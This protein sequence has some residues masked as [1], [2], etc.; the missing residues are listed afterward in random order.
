LSKLAWNSGSS[1]CSLSAEIIGMIRPLRQDAF[2]EHLLF[3]G[4]CHAL[5]THHLICSSSPLSWYTSLSSLTGK[6]WLLP[7]VP[8]QHSRPWVLSSS[9]HTRASY[10]ASPSL[11]KVLFAHRLLILT[12]DRVTNG[13][14][15][16][17]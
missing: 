17:T 3:A 16:G 12:Q 10:L 8:S 9:H 15:G 4:P 1:L 6:L 7:Q 13:M 14:W 2:I 5:N 11:G